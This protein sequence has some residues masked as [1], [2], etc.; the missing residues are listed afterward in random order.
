M[1]KKR[2]FA[3]KLHNME[4]GIS[5]VQNN[6]EIQERMSQYGY[7]P[8]RVAEGL[9]KLEE[10]KRLTAFHAEE[11]SDQYVATDKQNK[12]WTAIYAKYMITLKVVR[13]AFHREPGRLQDF[14]ATGRRH[15]SL[16]GWLNDARVLYTNLQ[17]TPGA[18]EKMTLYGY[19]A[20]RLQEEQQ[21]VE[22]VAQLH[23]KKLE[24]TGGAQQSTQERDRAFDDLC[25]WY[26]DF[27]SIARIALYD[28]PQLLEGLGIVKK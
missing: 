25:D 26:S 3:A 8:E 4:N 28:K 22:E 24:E 27:R 11:Y 20:E 12:S 14:Y 6:P 9:V 19:T 16:S 18:L 5:G 7:T 2:T 17:Q 15:R 13:V 1:N 10:V 21:Q 23:S